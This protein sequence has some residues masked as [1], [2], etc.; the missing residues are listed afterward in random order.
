M[1]NQIK[2]DLLKSMGDEALAATTYRLRAKKA[3]EM[4]AARYEEVAR[5]EDTHLQEFRKR[6]LELEPS[7]LSEPAKELWQ[8]DQ[9]DYVEKMLAL[10]KANPPYKGKYLNPET[11]QYATMQ[12]I[13]FYFNMKWNTAVE[14]A[15]MEGKPVPQEFIPSDLKPSQLR[16]G[17]NMNLKEALERAERWARAHRY[18][19][20]GAQAAFDYIVAYRQSRGQGPQPLTNILLSLREWTGPEAFDVRR[21]MRD[22]IRRLGTSGYSYLRSGRCENALANPPQC[23]DFSGMRASVMCRA[24]DMMDKKGLKSLP[25]KDAWAEAKSL[26]SKE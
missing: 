1:K 20:S 9:D 18:A 10:V 17:G 22:E 7:M 3:D 24:W 16:E 21:V 8:M 4:T 5:D 12:D 25:I 14:K 11:H 26:C 2:D 15:L 6:M 13:S 19:K 23:H